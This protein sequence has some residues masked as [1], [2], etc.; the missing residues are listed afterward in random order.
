LS[1][2]AADFPEVKELDINPLLV[3][4]SGI[5]ALDARVVVD[6]E[7]AG[8]PQR[9]Y[10]H[11]A[12]RPYPGEFVK[13]IRLGDGTEILLRPIKPEDEPLW[14]AL[15]GSCSRESIYSRFRHFF[16]WQSHEA[17]SRY[18]YIDYDRELAIVAEIGRGEARRLIGVGRLIANP[19]RSA[20]EYAVL[21]QDQWQNKG[22]GG[23]LTDY[24]SDIARQWGVRK[25]TAVTTSDNPRMVA[26]FVKRGFRIVKDLE[27][28]L[29]EVSKDLL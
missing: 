9:P 24:C 14:L 17:A 10:A 15:L 3:A 13:K 21:V 18:C 27:S 6:R 25:V 11:L 23:L 20:A 22:L 5:V 1:Y 8:D 7:A 28:P 4:A 16:F 2:L 29:V 12:L 19:E 26:V